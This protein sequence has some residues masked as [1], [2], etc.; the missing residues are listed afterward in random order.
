MIHQPAFWLSTLCRATDVPTKEAHQSANTK[1][2][3][4]TFAGLVGYGAR[5]APSGFKVP[6]VCA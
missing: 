2:A 3:L 1:G 6:A 4:L 5:R